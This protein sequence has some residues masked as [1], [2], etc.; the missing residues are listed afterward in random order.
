MTIRSGASKNQ[1][2]MPTAILIWVWFCAYLNCVG[3]TL[4]ALHQLNAAGYLVALLIGFVAFVAWWKQTS[5]RIFPHISWR[6]LKHRFRRPFPL[7]FLIL[8]AMAF[9]GGALYAPSN[10]DALAYRLPRILHWLAAGQWHWIHTIFSR[11]NDRACGI[12][13]VSAPF[14]ALVKTDRPLFL[15]NLVSFLLLPGL[16]F[17]VFTRLGVRRRVAWHWMWM[18]PTGYGFL[19]QAGSIGNDMFGAVFALAAVDFALRAR[20]SR[21][22]RDFFAS[23]LAA[24]L[25][26]GAKTSN[27]P[28]L[29]P[30]ALAIL[31][32]LRLGLRWPLRTA[33]ICLVAFAASVAPNTI[34]NQWYCGDWSGLRL[35]GDVGKPPPLF[36][37]GVNAV[38]I[39]WKNLSPPVF[40]FKEQWHEGLQQRLPP[41]L[42]GQLDRRM[43]TGLRCFDWSELQMEEGAGLGFGVCV[44]LAASV[45]AAGLARRKSPAAP[46]NGGCWSWQVWVRFAPVISLLALM[47]QS[48]L[49]AIARLL[50]PY[51]ALLLP[52]LLACAGHE[53]VVMQR[54]WRAAGL[55]V[56]SPPRPLFPVQTLLNRFQPQTAGSRLSARTREV[57]WVYRER[58]H[59]FAPAIAVLPPDSKIL[60]L[61][62]F[63]DPETSL[64]RPFGS[65]RIEHVC[66]EDTPADLKR[67]G[68]EYVLLREETLKIC[69]KC[70]LD[71]WLKQMNAQVVQ[72]I[73]LNLRASRGALDWYLVQLR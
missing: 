54:W 12:E 2:I 11:V 66:P 20:I 33:V 1:T 18:V 21:S 64:W 16:V 22:P 3:W 44:L 51:Y 25:M 49:T 37:A 56:I 41:A 10:Y 59:A 67:Q 8:A 23:M 46:P 19:L 7:A 57:Y 42:V 34:F 68:I 24:A 60:G 39:P 73:P 62:T 53:R 15:I 52:P 30:W 17:S 32:S 70:S 14:I 58:N 29:L 13:W 61:I 31:P 36:L 9:L 48:N 26:T 71:D 63:D 5:G 40:P 50:V 35:E 45:G 72:K 47:T 6:K 69:F 4:S 55:L 65:R 38:L 43:E 27:L 28:L